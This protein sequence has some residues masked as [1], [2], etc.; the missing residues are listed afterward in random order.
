MKAPRLY[1]E[2]AAWWPLLSPP[3]DYTDDSA[4][5]LDEI[6]RRIGPGRASLLDLGIGG[7]SL[8]AHFTSEAGGFD[9][10][11]VDLSSQMLEQCRRVNPTAE[12]MTGDMREIRLGREFDVVLMHDAVSYLLDVDAMR[13]ALETAW[14]HVHPGGMLM[15]CPDWYQE[16]FPTTLPAIRATLPA[17]TA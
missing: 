3:D 12:L 7:G 10:T 2:L 9:V 16:T 5:M 6:R 11:G 8:I 17:Q 14:V 13:A 15:L 1:T 4:R